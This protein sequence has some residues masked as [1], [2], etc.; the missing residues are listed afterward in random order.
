MKNIHVAVA[1]LVSLMSTNLLA[2]DKK[3]FGRN[4][5]LI[6]ADPAT[7]KLMSTVV[8][9]VSKKSLKGKPVVELRYPRKSFK[10]LCLGSGAKYP[11]MV[12][13]TREMNEEEYE[14]CQKNNIGS[15][16]KLKIGY[17][18]LVVAADKKSMDLDLDQ[19]ELFKALAKDVPNPEVEGVLVAN[20]Y[21]T[22]KDIDPAA[23]KQAIKIFGPAD[24]TRDARSV[25]VLG[26]EGGC[27]SW[28][29]IADMK[30]IQRSYRLY[31]ELC[32]VPREDGA[33]IKVPGT[34]EDL[35]KQL[36]SDKNS[37]GL[38]GYNKWL[39]AKSKLKTYAID[40][41]P[42]TMGTISKGLYPLSRSLYVYIKAENLKKVQG[43]PHIMGE[44]LSKK[45]LAADGYLA[46]IGLVA[47]PEKEMKR[48]IEQ[49]SE[50]TAMSKPDP[51]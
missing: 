14:R 15:I 3:D 29:W 16:I 37:V 51:S 35:I 4:N 11:D 43:L 41:L 26:M 47:M 30:N 19:R 27:R 12:A 9:K 34:D 45:A 17:E 39:K 31:R 1:I 50:F 13:A 2:E 21:K 28:D 38:M 36:L 40:D 18:A 32:H 48:E 8:S 42:P 25:S 24:K 22:W 46:E 7:M 33:Y 20:V 49:A 44:L 10:L 23:P 6:G 5:V